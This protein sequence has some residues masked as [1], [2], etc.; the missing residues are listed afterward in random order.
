[1]KGTWAPGA[2]QDGVAETG[3]SGTTAWDMPTAANAT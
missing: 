3:T 2:R 1:M